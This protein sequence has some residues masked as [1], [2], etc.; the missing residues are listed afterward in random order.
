M[1]LSMDLEG[2]VWTANPACLQ[3]LGFSPEE[4]IGTNIVGYLAAGE[5][6]R[7]GAMFG[8][9]LAGADYVTGEFKHVR[10]DGS[11]IDVDVVAHPILEDGRPVG[12]EGVARDVSERNALRD[13]LAHQAL[14]DALTGL[15]N[16]TLFHD[17][18]AQALARA[19]RLSSP[20]AVMLLDLDDFKLI[21]DTRGH[22]VGDQ[23]LVAVARRL[24]QELRRSESVARL[25]GDEFAF[26]VE[27]IKGE[28]ELAALA[29]RILSVVT[30]PVTV[31]DGLVHVAASLGIALTEPGE[32]TGALLRHADIAMYHAKADHR[33]HFAFYDPKAHEFPHANDAQR[34]A[35]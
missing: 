27:E 21:N 16:R 5:R 6:E 9:I 25:G 30:E 35:A 11:Q 2:N 32:D 3:V 7:A 28:L 19:E 20:V 15:P 31:V 1:I 8:Q 10:K 12:L 18:L 4:M 26:T 34:L 14:H 33:G 13:A 24:E 17:R 29:G 22:G 23:V